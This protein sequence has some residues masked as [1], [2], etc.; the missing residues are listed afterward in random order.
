MPPQGQLNFSFDIINLKSN[1]HHPSEQAQIKFF[2]IEQF[3]RDGHVS[4]WS[5]HVNLLLTRHDS[6]EQAWIIIDFI[7]QFRCTRNFMAF[8]LKQFQNRYHTPPTEKL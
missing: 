5:K 8:K 1:F 3:Q 4:H 2:F 7:Q 6:S